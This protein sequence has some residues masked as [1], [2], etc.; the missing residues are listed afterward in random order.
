MPAKCWQCG[1]SVEVPH[2]DTRKREFCNTCAET[3]KNQYETDLKE[4]LRLKAKLMV[5]RAIKA[6]EKQDIV[7]LEYKEAISVVSDFSYKNPE[8]FMSAEEIIAAIVLIN[9]RVDTKV[10][11]KINNH[12]VDFLLPDLKVALEI[13]GYMHAHTQVKDS[14]RDIEIRQALGSKWEVVRIPTEYINQNA[15]MLLEAISA[16]VEKKKELRAQNGGILPETYSKREKMHYAK[17]GNR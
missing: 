12:Q 10:Q 11:H 8:K 7:I 13:D 17:L 15:K 6:F 4:Y 3:N 1:K 9:S 2:Y 14:R 5:N 16:I